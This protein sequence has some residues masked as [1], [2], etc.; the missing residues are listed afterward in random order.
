MKGHHK[1]EA[2]RLEFI[3]RSVLGGDE[4]EQ[5]R[6]P[7]RGEICPKC[8]KGKLDYDGMLNLRCEACGYAVV[9]CFT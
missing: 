8:G 3:L 2:P 5:P 9:G 6:E 4:A 7:R 1:E